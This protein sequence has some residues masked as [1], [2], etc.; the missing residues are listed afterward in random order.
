MKRFINCTPHKIM[1]NDGTEFPPSGT[2]A[3]VSSAF[4]EPDADLICTP[5]FGAVESLPLSVEGTFY[6]VSAMVLSAS[7]RSDLVAPATGHPNCIRN[8]AGQIVSVPC[9]VRRAK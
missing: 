1:L 5:V 8:E 3:R 2:V 9:F 4:S 6:I 7:K